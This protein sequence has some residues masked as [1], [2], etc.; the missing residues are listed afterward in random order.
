MRPPAALRALGL[1]LLLAGVAVLAA[2]AIA[3]WGLGLGTPP[4]Y[5][6]HPSIEYLFRANQDL[7]RFHNRIAINAYGMR[8]PALA[9]HPQQ[10]TRRI[11]VFGDSVVFGGSQLDQ[12]VIATERLGPLLPGSLRPFSSG[13]IE[14]G[15]VSGGSWGPGNWLAWARTYGFLGATDV[16]LVVSS[17][18][19]RDNPSFAP[20]DADHP[21]VPPGSALQELLGRYLWPRIASQLPRGSVSTVSPNRAAPP[22]PDPASPEALRRGLADLRRFLMLARSS[23]ARVSVVQFWERRE[24]V[25]GVPLAEHDAI[26]ALLRQERIP[27]VQAGPIFRRCSRR[28]DHGYD[29]LVVDRIHPFTAAG[30]ACLA[31]AIAEALSGGT[32]GGPP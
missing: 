26:A 13:P 27:A 22:G 14:I 23:G 18:D 19:A 32:S 31:E 17:H 11:L 1:G 9:A 15:N 30:Q 6:S 10:G 5:V 4:L 20:L 2:E 28:A 24:L 3:R 12:A 8:S 21:T 16:V 25:S 7:R 29:D